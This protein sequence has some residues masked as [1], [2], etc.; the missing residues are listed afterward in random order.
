MSKTRPQASRRAGL[1][2]HYIASSH[3]DREWYEPFQHYRFR[4]V[5]V[6]DA[7]IDL[8]EHDP[9]YR[10]F[11]TDG[12]SVVLEDYLEIRPERRAQLKE[13]IG[14]GRLQ[15]GPWYVQPDEF[16]VAGESLVRNLLRG[17]Q[18]AGEFG[19]P[20][21]VGFACDIFGHNSQLPQVFRGF[22]IDTAVVWRGTNFPPDPGLFRWQAADGS[23]V[24]AY[25]F[26][27][28]GYGHYQFD[29]RDPAKTP[30]GKL[31]FARALAGLRKMFAFEREHVPGD[32]ILLFDGIDH[33]PPEPATSELLARARKAGLHIQHSRL[34]DFF[35]AVRAQRLKLQVHRG[36]LRE[37]GIRLNWVIPGVLSSRIYLK[38]H[39]AR[40]EHRLLQWAEPLAA[41]A[42][43]LG[44]EYPAA[45]L[46]LAW[47]YLLRNHPHDSICGCSID[48]VHR[49]MLYRF[50]QCRL[51]ADRAT[52]MALRAIADRTHL[53]KLKGEEDFAVTVFNPGSA[54][55]DGVVDLPLYFR[56]DTPH[57]FHEW[58]G[59]EPIVGFRLYD[60]GG[61][62][63]PYQRLDVTKTAP[64][65]TYDRL[66]GYA[67]SRCE[68]VNVALRLQV[69][70]HGW[71]TFVCRP[72]KEKTR[73][74]GS[75][76][77]DDHTMENEF[78]RVSVNPN[79]TL[80]LTDRKA[81]C[82]YRQALTFEDRADIGDGWY[83]GTAVNDEVFTSLGAAADIAVVHDGFAL[84]TLRVRVVMNV[85][86]CFLHD[87]EVMRRSPRLVP[88]EIISFLMLRA[89]SPY[90]EVRTEVENTVRD[91]RLRVLVPTHLA[92]ETYFAD[93]PFDVVE[94]QIALRPDSHLLSEPE[95]ETKPQYSFTAVNDG[96][97]GLAVLATGQ[98]ESAV[99]DLPDRPIAL[100][101][102]RGFAKT[103]GTAGEPGAQMLGRTSHTYW[104][105]PHSGPLPVTE[106]LHLGQRLAAGVECIYTEPP[107]QKLLRQKPVLPATG[108]WVTL[109]PGPLV[110]TACKRAE[111]GAALVLRAFN[112]TDRPAR[113]RFEFLAPVRTAHA[114]NLLEEPQRPLDRRGKTVTVP[115]GPKEIVT[116]R[117]ELNAVSSRIV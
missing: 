65:R 4:L 85:P 49:D 98:P 43:L 110:I 81:G 31:D 95:L 60:A 32:A 97:R 61:Q 90:L 82:T 23:E 117:V 74:V 116:L 103:V 68:Q 86:E 44:H 42:S 36:E 91:H 76:L 25:T 80:D 64:Y 14:A 70:P 7:V 94:R 55:L 40:C 62:E 77:I 78:L 106:L 15:V 89:G 33:V 34:V 1:T 87:R 88:L 19:P 13:L 20:M 5:D 96:R 41:W 73:S 27:D 9:A 54:A 108:S 93:S 114:A 111:D 46:R 109:G 16:L 57:R 69:P 24:L 48:Q 101:L 63:V 8:L 30:A 66:A 11:Q 71:T 47:K 22:G 18:V 115:A 45:H 51:V 6:L 29:V 38:Q 2:A 35:A 52:H 37:P 53:P 59:Y 75:Q 67:D 104:L 99:R 3:W 92:A 84:T 10:F 107:R 21:K 28:R 100:T 72:T 12:Q 83:H 56:R 102:L 113:Q 39:N 105:Y 17:H 50:D 26:E 112:P 58:F 79:G